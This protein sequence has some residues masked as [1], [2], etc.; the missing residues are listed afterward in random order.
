M[1]WVWIS[2]CLMWQG[3]SGFMIHNNMESLCLEDSLRDGGVQ[4][5]RCS[6]NS[7]LQQWVWT[8]RLF[9]MNVHT[10]RC[11]SAFPTNP[12]QTLDC[13]GEEDLQWQCM[14]HRLISLSYSLELGVHRGSLALINTG[15]STRWKSLDQGDICQEKLRSRR[16][17]ETAEFQATEVTM[18]EKER[19]Y[20]RWYYRTEDATPW[21]F[22]MLV[23]SFVALL[24]GGVLCVMGTM[25]NKHRR[26]IAKYKTTIAAYPATMKV[27]ME[28]LQVITEIKEDNDSYTGQTQDGQL[29]SK[30]PLEGASETEELK[31]G[32][33]IVTWKDGNVSKLNS[34]S[35]EEGEEDK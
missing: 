34:D 29:D 20:L 18:T 10:Q 31:P 14:N 22:A 30:A 23:L 5:K 17:S 8:E 2:L 11:L 12:I 3:T 6:V 27:E 15:K 21:K 28:K 19:K 4:L 13:N 25:N 16:D 7:E 26:E 32:D 24:L 9:L 33:I 1:L 35:Q